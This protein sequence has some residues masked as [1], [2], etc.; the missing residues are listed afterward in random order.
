MK[1]FTDCKTAEQLKKAYRA[2]AM[3]LHPDMGGD[4]A[5]F[6]AMQNEFEQM[7]ERLKNIH[8]N[9]DGETYE[10]TTSEVAS[11]F[12]NIIE[13]LMHMDGVQAEIC[14]S[15]LWVS[16][17][18]LPYKEHL[19]TLGGRWSNNKKCWYIHNEPYNRHSKKQYTLEEI[20]E[21]YG[22]QTVKSE[23]A[24]ANT[25]VLTA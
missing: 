19:K 4:T 7:W 24:K 12:M 10:K 23:S 14:G 13:K 22:S 17:N 21:M 9:K 18:T 6:Q 20:R 5:E 15:W 8:A 1:Y 11:E 3:K 2:L 25:A 16:G